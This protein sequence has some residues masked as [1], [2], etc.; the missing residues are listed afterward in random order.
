MGLFLRIR[1]GARR[2]SLCRLVWSYTLVNPAAAAAAGL[3]S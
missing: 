1:A 2:R 3:I